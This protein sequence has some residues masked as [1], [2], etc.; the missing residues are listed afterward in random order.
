MK[1]MLKLS[2]LALLTLLPE[3]RPA[4][5][6]AGSKLSDTLPL[7]DGTKLQLTWLMPQKNASA[8]RALVIIQHGMMRHA[9]NMMA[10][11]RS[12]TLRNI[13]VLLPDLTDEHFFNPL[14]PEIF[15]RAIAKKTVDPQGNPLPQKLLLAGFSAGARFLS[16]VAGLLQTEHL[17]LRGVLLLDPVIGEN[18]EQQLGPRLDV[19][20]FTILAKPSRCNADGRIYPLLESGL[21]ETQGF[22]LKSASHCDFEGKSSDTLCYLYCGLSHQHNA[23]AVELFSTEWI[24]GL[25][26]ND[27]PSVDFL[28]GGQVF[29]TWNKRGVFD[30]IFK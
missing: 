3:Y 28:P 14:F 12:L 7:E 4:Q 10:L 19:P 18:P 23:Q 8:P 1:L 30:T 21:F 22:R 26:D 24:S 15:A 2:L 29:E 6:F 11:A 16:R 27:S 17:K 20:Y 25:I 9:I 13:E 5:A